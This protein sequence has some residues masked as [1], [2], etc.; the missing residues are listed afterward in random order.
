MF[1]LRYL[2]LA[3]GAL[4]LEGTL[5]SRLPVAGARPDLALA[6][7]VYA[8][9][10]GGGRGGVAIGFLL[11]LLRGWSEPGWLGLETL[12]LSLTGFAAGVTSP[13]VNRSSPWVQALL[14]FLLLLAHD[15]VRSFWLHGFAPAPALLAW[16]GSAPMTALYTALLVPICVALF[17]RLWQRREAHELS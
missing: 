3:F 16:V 6:L 14:I 10:F 15:L 17:P 11:G 1:Y 9:L 12:L 4:L 8:G 5:L 13:M 2:L 7:A